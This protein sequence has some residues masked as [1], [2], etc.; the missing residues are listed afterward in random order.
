MRLYDIG[1][2]WLSMQYWWNDSGR[3]ELKYLQK[4][5]SHCNF[6]TVLPAWIGLGSIVILCGVRLVTNCMTE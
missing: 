4:H 3:R 1:E 5:L 6:I 2:S